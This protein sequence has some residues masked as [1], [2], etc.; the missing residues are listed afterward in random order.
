MVRFET[1]PFLRDR[2]GLKRVST[3]PPHEG[4]GEDGLLLE[5]PQLLTDE[6]TA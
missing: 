4:G 1:C 2:D 3:E 6:R 5:L